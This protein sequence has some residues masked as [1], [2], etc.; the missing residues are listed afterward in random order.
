M[1]IGYMGSV[2]FVVS[3]HY[4]ITTSQVQ[5]QDSGRWTEHDLI[6]KKPVSQ[7]KG[8]GLGKI[9]FKL[10]LRADHN[11]S[12]SS[13]LRILRQMCDSGAVFPLV[14]GGRPVS[15]NYW[16]LDALSQDENFYSP[17]GKLIQTN[18]SVS[19]TEY[20]DSNYIEEK[21]A[22]DKYG[23]IGNALAYIL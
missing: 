20:D 14:I 6:H 16:R 23:A 5:R 18:V 9:S 17:T 1:Y 3:S 15:Q 19:L 13:Q 10:Q 7:F 21:T 22:V 4:M 11:V 2:V 12:P 8:P